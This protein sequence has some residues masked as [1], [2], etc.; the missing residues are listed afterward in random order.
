ME[1]NDDDFLSS[2]D[3]YNDDI[4]CTTATSNVACHN[5]NN[6]ILILSFECLL[7]SHIAVCLCHGHVMTSKL[8]G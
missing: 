3:K 8:L 7:L 4:D 2:E 1:I 5:D 6:I